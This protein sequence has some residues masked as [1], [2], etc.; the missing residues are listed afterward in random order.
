V[1]LDLV[2]RIP[3]KEET[4]EFLSDTSSSKRAKVIDKLIAS[5]VV[6]HFCKPAHR[7][8]NVEGQC[9]GVVS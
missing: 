5:E 7:V 1:Y 6:V 3:T 4:Q 2:G 8:C 9:P